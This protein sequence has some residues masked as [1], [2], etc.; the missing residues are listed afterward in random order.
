MSTSILH[1]CPFCGCV[2]DKSTSF[3]AFVENPHCRQCGLSASES[4]V[5]MQEELSFLFAKHMNMGP[6][7]PAQSQDGLRA[8]SLPPEVPKMTYRVSQH[9]HHSSHVALQNRKEAEDGKDSRIS[10][11]RGP[12]ADDILRSH[13]ID[14][15]SLSMDQLRLFEN[16]DQEQRSRLIQMWQLCS[17]KESAIPGDILTRGAR[18]SVQASPNEAGLQTDH[19]TPMAEMI[20][21]EQYA[22]PYMISGYETLAQRDYELSANVVSAPETDGHPVIAPVLETESSYR[23]ATD[24]VYQ[25]QSRWEQIDTTRMEDQYGRFCQTAQYIGC[26]IRDARWF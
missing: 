18:Q 3:A 9:Y 7:V 15:L 20:D 26:G 21:E 1:N 17:D 13:D 24:P 25:G 14:P 23:Q 22:E 5:T 19:P 16:A 12:S 11:R 8:F 2:S 4:N 6:V 10:F